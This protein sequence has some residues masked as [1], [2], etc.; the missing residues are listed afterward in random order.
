VF[1]LD[2]AA[3]ELTRCGLRIALAPQP[4]KVRWLL[5]SRAGEVVT[6]RELYELLWGTETHV[7]FDDMPNYCL[8]A[9]RGALATA[10]D[11]RGS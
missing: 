5:A 2:A 7:E 1:D 3:G 11:N 9:T 8:A 4:F 6:P 10:R